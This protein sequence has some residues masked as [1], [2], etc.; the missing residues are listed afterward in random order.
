MRWDGEEENFMQ[1][2]SNEAPQGFYDKELADQAHEKSERDRLIE[3]FQEEIA[4]LNKLL[5]R[6]K[7]PTIR[8]TY[9]QV[10]AEKQNKLA[11]LLGN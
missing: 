10:I 6:E 9:E 7:N 4:Q 2:G 3:L 5:K 8:Q 1:E 11:E